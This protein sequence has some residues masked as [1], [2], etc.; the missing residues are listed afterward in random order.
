MNTGSLGSEYIDLD[1]GLA[2]MGGNMALYK[3]LLGRFVGD[4]LYSEL[5][6]FIM[7]GNLDDAT[8]QAHSIKGVSG[9]LSLMKL[10]SI[11]IELERLLKEKADYSSQLSEMKQVYDNTIEKIRELID[12]V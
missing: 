12:E 7:S 9:N 6:G 4:D 11:S 1:D 2:R 8:R 5:E 10:N 3:R